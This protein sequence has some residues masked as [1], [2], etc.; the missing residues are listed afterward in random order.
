MNV[1][2]T[3]DYFQN[4]QIVAIRADK[5]DQNTVAQIEALL[6]ELGNPTKAIP[7]YALYP[8]NGGPPQVIDGLIPAQQVI[9]QFESF[10][11]A[12]SSGAEQIAKA[13]Q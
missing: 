6:V 4:H 3:F 2:E 10:G 11:D 13:N 12:T 7:F 8:G 5:G 1:K 9:N